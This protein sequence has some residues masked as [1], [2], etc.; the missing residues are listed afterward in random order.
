MRALPIIV[1]SLILLASL[2]GVSLVV[3]RRGVTDGTGVDRRERPPRRSRTRSSKLSK[4]RS[5]MCSAAGAT[6]KRAAIIST[7]R[8]VG[9]TAIRIAVVFWD[10]MGGVHQVEASCVYVTTDR[11][12]AL[13][14]GRGHLKRLQ[15][16]GG[17]RTD[18]R[19][20]AKNRLRVVW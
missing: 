3:V 13:S 9:V 1:W 6:A 10:V 19:V 17:R 18:G 4:S 15:K 14:H 12:K 7:A 11:A 16:Q 8:Y 20:A 5:V 2:C